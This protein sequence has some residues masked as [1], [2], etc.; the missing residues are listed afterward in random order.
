M[1]EQKTEKPIL[2]TAP[3]PNA[4]FKISP[5]DFVFLQNIKQFYL[6]FIHPFSQLVAAVESM[7]QKF[8]EDGNLVYLYPGDTEDA[9][10]EQGN[11]V[12]GAN[13][14]PIPKLTEQFSNRFDAIN[15]Q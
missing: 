13:G 7:E 2:G 10:D 14:K 9:K 15:R 5:S 4:E 11:V 3:R 8:L 12:I 1:E 6:N